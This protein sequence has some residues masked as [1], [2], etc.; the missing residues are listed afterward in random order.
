[1]TARETAVH[2]LKCHP[3]PFRALLAGEKT[4]EWRRDDRR[5]RFA[6]GDRLRLFEWDPSYDPWGMRDADGVTPAPRG[7]TG[8]ECHVRVTYVSHSPN[9]GI[10]S[11]WCVMSIRLEPASVEDARAP[12]APAA[13]EGTPDDGC[14][15]PA[16]LR[17][18]ADQREEALGKCNPE[19]A[20]RIMSGLALAEYVAFYEEAM[21]LPRRVR[22]LADRMEREAAAG[23]GPVTRADLSERI[24]IAGVWYRREAEYGEAPFPPVSD[25][26]AVHPRYGFAC[27][28]PEGHDGPH[29]SEGNG[30]RVVSWDREEE[31]PPARTPEKGEADPE[32]LR[33][34][35][36]LTYEEW[37]AT[38]GQSFPMTRERW[39]A[40]V[41]DARC[42]APDPVYAAPCTRPAGHDGS[43]SADVP[44]ADRFADRIPGAIRAVRWG[45]DHA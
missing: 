2:A 42:G 25:C 5:P 43:H 11:G 20:A 38:V 9:F 34:A 32:P 36:G 17:A 10:P 12:E 21:A 37:A 14:A 23:I 15:T 6:A 31:A 7:Y 18:F 27:D 28:N 39:E 30:E 44:G 41:T 1:M 45:G 24:C 4:H 29:A 13:P 19:E 22:A 26:T 40:V 8:R 33:N 3:E 35:A 16:E